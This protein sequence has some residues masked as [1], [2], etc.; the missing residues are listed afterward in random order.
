MASKPTHPFTVTHKTVLHLAVPMTLAY[1]STPILGLVDTAVVGQFGSAA[2]IG[3]LAVG[4]I[5]ID[6]VFVTYNFLRSG[7]SGLTAQAHGAQ[8]EKEK[9][10]ILFRSLIIAIVSGLMMLIASPL[11]LWLGKWFMQPTEAVAQATSTY[12]LIRMISAPF[13]LGNYAMLGWLLGI[14]KSKTTL[15][16]QLVLN[17]SNIILSFYLGLY[18]GWEI[19][20]VA[21]ATIIGELL[22]FIVGIVICWS[23]LDHSIRPSKKRVFDK[24]SWMRLINLNADIMIRSFALLLAFAYFTAQGAAFGEVTLAANAILM[25]LFLTAGYF[26]DGLATAAEQIIGKA[27]GAN[28]KPA[29]WKGFKL[30]LFWSCV[31]A[32]ICTIIFWVFGSVIIELLTVN[33]TVR[34]EAHIY[35][36]WAALIP[37]TGMLAFQLDGVFIGAT[38]SRDMSIMMI[39]SLALYLI[40]WQVLKAPFGN[41]GLWL[42]LHLFLSFRA[43]TLAFRLGPNVKRTFIES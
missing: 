42:A 17:G 4:A 24:P 34:Q 21:I 16:L 11:I 5:I 28:Y 8:D 38:W 13:A 18:L 25:H 41:H 19:T 26:L 1:L 12:F 40:S 6:L 9:Q 36:I 27:V 32:L 14:G 20:G 43:V 2:L 33:E 37:L 10:A 31:M 29:F 3:G 7:T 23:L 22:A 15:F 35:L 30:T 39:I